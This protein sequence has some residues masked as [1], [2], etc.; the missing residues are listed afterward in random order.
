MGQS[1]ESRCSHAMDVINK[2]LGG[3]VGKVATRPM[4]KNVKLV[5]NNEVV[6]VITPADAKAD[7]SKTAA[8]L[9]LKWQRVL[10]RAFD[11]SKAQK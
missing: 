7:R 8:Q 10:A 2:Y 5:L 6:A 11:A 3:K 9:A 4:G 1:P